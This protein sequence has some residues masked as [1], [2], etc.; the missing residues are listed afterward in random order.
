MQFNLSKNQFLNIRVGTTADYR[1]FTYLDQNVATYKGFD[2]EFIQQLTDKL[3]IKIQLIKTTWE[4]LEKNL[5]DCLFDMAVGGIS[6][7]EERKQKFLVSSPIMLDGK[8]ILIRR[9][10]QN[11][12]K[13]IKDVDVSGITVIANRGGTNEEFV[14]NNIKRAKVIVFHDNMSI[15]TKLANGEADV[16]ITD[17]LEALYRQNLDPRLYVVDPTIPLTE[18]V[19]Y[20]YLY[21]KDNMELRNIIEKGLKDF[22]VTEDFK[23]LFTKFFNFRGIYESK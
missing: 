7:T 15:F 11:K 20:G 10:H 12:I 5:T 9:K 3:G 13:T 4:S 16:M 8:V 17:C 23:M 18:P 14:K 22:M 21:N 2:I 6:L 19:G 1:P